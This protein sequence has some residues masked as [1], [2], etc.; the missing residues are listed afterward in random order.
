MA[1]LDFQDGRH[2][3]S[4][5]DNIWAC[6]PVR[7]PVLVSKYTI[8]ESRNALESLQIALDDYLCRYQINMF[9]LALKSHHFQNRYIRSHYL[10]FFGTTDSILKTSHVTRTRHAHQVSALTLA[11]LQ[12]D[13]N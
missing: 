4:I 11:K 2:V 5:S 3:K 7:T 9:I 1:I 10:A 13:G 8:S 6:K 12:Q